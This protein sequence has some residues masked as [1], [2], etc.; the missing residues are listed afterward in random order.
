[1]LSHAIQKQFNDNQQRLAQITTL[2]LTQL[3]IDRWKNHDYRSN[4]MHRQM[5][6][7]DGFFKCALNE[8]LK[9]VIISGGTNEGFAHRLCLGCLDIYMGA[10]H[11]QKLETSRQLFNF[12]RH[13][14]KSITTSHIPEME[15]VEFLLP[16]EVGMS[17]I[18]ITYHLWCH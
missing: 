4:K 15:K 18:Q 11:N 9:V 8:G 10:H 6:T 17:K 5:D 2:Y 12:P 1:M 13:I 7:K 16:S 14:F 3:G